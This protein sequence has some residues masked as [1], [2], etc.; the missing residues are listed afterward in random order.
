M[1]TRFASAV[2]RI[3]SIAPIDRFLNGRGAQWPTTVGEQ[4][5]PDSLRIIGLLN[6]H[7]PI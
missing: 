7:L 4:R 5:Q 3:L 6:C 2:H 1:P